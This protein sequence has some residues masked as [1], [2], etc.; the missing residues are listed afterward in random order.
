VL[1]GLA[2]ASFALGVVFAFV[3]PALA[4]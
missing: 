1:Y 2:G 4:P 3:L